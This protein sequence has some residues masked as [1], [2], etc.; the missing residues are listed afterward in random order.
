MLVD[1]ARLEREYHGRKPVG[2]K[3]SVNGAG[4]RIAREHSIGDRVILVLEAKVKKAGH[5]DTDDGLIYTEVLKV[6]DLFEV[7]GVPGRT[8]ISTMRSAH[9]TAAEKA[10]GSAPI[11][12]T[13]DVGYADASGIVLTPRE[14][15]ALRGDPV[16][17]MVTERLMPAVV[18]YDD[19]ARQLWPD[20]FAVDVARPHIGQKILDGETVRTVLTL[21]DAE[22]GEELDVGQASDDII[23]DDAPAP[24]FA[25]A[26]D[27][28]AAPDDV[29]PFDAPDAPADD[30]P[31]T[32]EAARLEA[33][34]PTQADFTFVD[35]GISELKDAL[36]D[37]TDEAQLRRLVNAEKQG[38]GRG[39]KY[40][41]GALDAIHARLEKVASSV[42]LHLVK[43][44]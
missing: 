32:D 33:E 40:R 41:K 5:E 25:D 30:T 2:M 18:V 43:E 4:N 34:L 38:R 37:V 36:E 3:T 29:P 16:R 20:D 8:L 10:A 11:P 13:G 24:D 27:F 31:P 21:L 9:R 26:G 19:E 42:R 44:A 22:T 35:V 28:A 12:G 7:A 17:A 15:A 6:V 23:V 39:L 14:V 1:V